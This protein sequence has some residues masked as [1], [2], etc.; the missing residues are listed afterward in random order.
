MSNAI[1][2]RSDVSKVAPEVIEFRRHLHQYPELSWKEKETQAFVLTQ[3]EALK[4]QDVRPVARTGATALISGDAS[5]PCVLWRADM[6]ALPIFEKTDLS[7]ASKN[8]GVMHACGHDV[9]TAIGLGL[10]RLLA[11]N[12]KN[13]KG[14]VRLLF[15]P[16]EESTSGARLCIEEGILDSPNV[17][18]VLGLHISAD[19]PIGSINVAAGPFFAAPTSFRIE[20]Q[21]IGG[22]AA[23]PNQAVD[24]VV[25]AAQIINALQ[26]VVSRSVSPLENAVV[27]I[28]K[29]EAG[30]RGNVIAESALMTGT[31]RTYSV[32]VRDLILK[33]VESLIKG[34]CDG[35]N[36]TY[37]FSH[38]SDTPALVNDVQVTNFVKE[39]AKQ[40]FGSDTYSVPTMGA[41]DMSYFLNERPGC[42]FWLGARN[43]AKG[44][45]G[46]H[47]DSAFVIDEDAIALGL[48]FSRILIEKSLEE[49]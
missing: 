10:A 25:I 49:L 16:A 18:R 41:E 36:A 3:L 32:E 22:H 48:D 17:D 27:T 28:G 29:V 40:F 6:D 1:E 31:I 4:L 20:I 44:I 2:V 33:R 26:T 42:Y 23:L 46:R 8:D 13:L 34:I 39:E 12:S 35:F 9:H 30:V 11:D 19:V 38:R 24:T 21:G 5:G 15:Q 45:A 43:E 7:Y 37:I 14:S 47:H